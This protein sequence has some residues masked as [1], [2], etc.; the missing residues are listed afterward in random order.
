M[1]EPAPPQTMANPL[2]LIVATPWPLYGLAFGCIIVMALAWPQPVGGGWG[3]ATA[4]AAALGVGIS[5]P[6]W[7]AA[8]NE[9]R[10]RGKSAAGGMVGV[11]ACGM[12][13]AV[14]ALHLLNAAVGGGPA[15]SA[16]LPVVDKYTSRGRR[17]TS[18]FVITDPVP[19]FGPDS[20]KHQVG[21]LMSTSGHYA[22]YT[23]GG[24]MAL[25]W[26]AGWLW[27]VVE[28]ASAEPCAGGSGEW[29]DGPAAAPV[30]GLPPAVNGAG[31]GDVMARIRHASER[32]ALP[33][34]G[35]ALNLMVTVDADGRITRLSRLATPGETAAE[36][37]TANLAEA[38][39]APALIDAKGALK[40]PGRFE[41]RLRLLPQSPA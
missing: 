18:Y 17:S 34:Q 6:F 21:G 25:R 29:A 10:Q 24:C 36:T 2:L 5:L 28:R 3:L 16:L 38:V 23:V 22:D 12:L 27:P 9:A 41:L 15:Q 1:S 31:W 13:V 4:V 33:D 7:P 35:V 26:R 30:P 8:A 14:T 20:G 19:G 39:I 37:A 32:L 11:A 40:G